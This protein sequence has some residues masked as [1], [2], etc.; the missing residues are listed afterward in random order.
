MSHSA[1]Y[2]LRHV[3][4]CIGRWSGPNNRISVVNQQ[5]SLSSHLDKP[6]SHVTVYVMVN[7]KPCSHEPQKFYPDPSWAQNRLSCNTSFVW[8]LIQSSR[9]YARTHTLTYI[10]TNHRH[11]RTC[12]HKYTHTNHRYEHPCKRAHKNARMHVHIFTHRHTCTCKHTCTHPH[13]YIQCH[14]LKIKIRTGSINER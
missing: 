6:G 10:H 12:N 8:H 5:F 2:V 7:L 13:A 1:E 9:K 11:K 4:S 14:E 3:Q